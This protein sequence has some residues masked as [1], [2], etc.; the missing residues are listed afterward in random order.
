MSFVMYRDEMRNISF[1][2]VEVFIKEYL[3]SLVKKSNTVRQ[4]MKRQSNISVHE[5][6]G[7]RSW[8]SLCS[9][10]YPAVQFVARI[11]IIFIRSE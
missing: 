1:Q 7:S 4:K 11:C 2:V 10:V 6:L 5:A 9:L 3:D 8:H